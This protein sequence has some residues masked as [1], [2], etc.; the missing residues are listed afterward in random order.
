MKRIKANKLGQEKTAAT[1]AQR[2]TK[3]LLINNCNKFRSS[4][5]HKSL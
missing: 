3:V 5:D 1:E 2:I 4:T